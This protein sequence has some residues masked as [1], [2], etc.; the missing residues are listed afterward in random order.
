MLIVY[1]QSFFIVNNSS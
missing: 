1:N